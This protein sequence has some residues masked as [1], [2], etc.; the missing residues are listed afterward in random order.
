MSFFSITVTSNG[1]S[2]IQDLL[3]IEANSI[4]QWVSQ[5]FGRGLT[6]TFTVSGG[7]WDRIR[8]LL[9]KASNRRIIAVD[10]SGVP[11]GTGKK[12]PLLTYTADLI[13]GSRPM[14]HQLEGVPVSLAAPADITVQ[15][16]GL[17]A[18]T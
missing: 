12:M 11:L 15:G 3:G 7:V 16:T 18:G 4:P 13:P 1:N 14:I 6:T 10:S 9:N 2:T 8:P 5:N 17:L